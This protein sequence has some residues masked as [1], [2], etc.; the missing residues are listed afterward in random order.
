MNIDEIN[1]IKY[2]QVNG[3]NLRLDS[4]S[5]MIFAW[6]IYKTKI[7]CWKVIKFTES[8]GYLKCGIRG[9]DYRKHRL[10]YYANNQEWDI[11]NSL[12]SN[13]IDHIDGNKKNNNISNLRVVTHQWNRKSAKGYTWDK[14][15]KKWRSQLMLNKKKIYLG[16]FDNKDKARTAYLEAKEIYHKI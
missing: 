14:Q 12:S 3:Q 11:N 9:K 6:R 13:S 10:V 15:S 2:F 8:N 16:L 5:N 7:N 4:V 1:E